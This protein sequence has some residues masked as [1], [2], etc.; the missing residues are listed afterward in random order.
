V[1]ALVERERRGSR[2]TVTVILL[3]VA[4]LAL[5]G[6][7][8]RPLWLS[9]DET[10]TTQ[11]LSNNHDLVLAYSRIHPGVTRASELAGYGFD[12]SSRGARLL[13]YLA[14]MESFIPHDSEQFDRLDAAVQTCVA[15][16]ERCSA[17]I[18]QPA[19]SPGSNKAHGIFTAFGMGAE[20]AS[21]TPQVTLLIRD[22]RVTFKLMTGAIATARASHSAREARAVPIP[23]RMN[24]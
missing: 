23:F 16:R 14:I 9:S 12:S 7:A 5:L 11:Q 4:I 2:R 3:C 20:A 22:G 6:N 21:R 17:L 13:S 18:F 8:M 24:E 19:D 15:A 1:G 10:R